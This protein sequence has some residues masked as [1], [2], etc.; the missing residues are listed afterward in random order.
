MRP[1]TLDPTASALERVGGPTSD[2]TAGERARRISA[3][4]EAARPVLDPSDPR[5]G[6]A[7]REQENPR[8]SSS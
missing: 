6:R 5:Y 4:P 3:H 1:S 2:P 7:P 8:V